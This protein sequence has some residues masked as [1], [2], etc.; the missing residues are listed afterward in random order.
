MCCR[1]CTARCVQYPHPSEC[2]THCGPPLDILEFR[3]DWVPCLC[4]DRFHSASSCSV[5]ECNLENGSGAQCTATQASP[6]EEQYGRNKQA[7][8]CTDVEKLST[9][10][11]ECI[12]GRYGCPYCEM[13]FDTEAAVREHVILTHA[14]VRFKCH[15]CFLKSHCLDEVLEHEIIAHRGVV[16]RTCG[17][18]RRT[19]KMFSRPVTVSESQDRASE[20]DGLEAE[21]EQGKLEEEDASTEEDSSKE[22]YFQVEEHIYAEGYGH[23]EQ[24][25]YEE[26]YEYEQDWDW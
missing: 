17:G 24:Y 6:K 20:A 16:C 19:E 11:W 15:L 22:K 3:P 5:S 2:G 18:L 7:D 4:S 25:E 12:C 8:E 9:S 10:P 13:D 1:C 23:D 26:E 21:D 14:G